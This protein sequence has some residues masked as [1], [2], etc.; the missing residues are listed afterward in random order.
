MFT[1]RI[2]PLLLLTTLIAISGN[3]RGR[4]TE[5]TSYQ[6]LFDSADVVAVVSL[7]GKT[8]R[9]GK[10]EFLEG[11]QKTFD[12]VKTV[13]KKHALFKGEL[14]LDEWSYL[15]YAWPE[16]TTTI[17]NGP[18]FIW[19]DDEKLVYLVFLK[20]DAEGILTPVTGQTQVGSS[21][22]VL[23]ADGETMIGRMSWLKPN[24][25]T[26]PALEDACP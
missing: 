14:D 11:D 26:A 22:L 16:D 8:E 19:F 6:R 18:G 4:F 25:K 5:I 20:R 12:V 1:A 24:E 21:F 15:H 7:K 13:F 17:V 2:S 23:Q 9:T 10:T 3:S